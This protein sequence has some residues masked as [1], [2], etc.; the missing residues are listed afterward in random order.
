MS[1][2]LEDVLK[3]M[4]ERREGRTTTDR[5]SAQ[6]LGRQASGRSS[7]A[8]DLNNGVRNAETGA[9]VVGDTS[10]SQDLRAWE[11][12]PKAVR[13]G[14]ADAH[15]EISSVEMLA[16]QQQTFSNSERRLMDTLR[17]SVTVVR[18][19]LMKPDE[20]GHVQTLVANRDWRDIRS[21]RPGNAK[22]RAMAT[23]VRLKRHM[24]RKAKA[25]I[26]PKPEAQ[27]GDDRLDARA[28]VDRS[29]G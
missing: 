7:G 15:Y 14:L 1:T 9:R 18:E 21:G 2:D 25:G 4:Q 19:H 10:A 27:T 6:S 22:G 13:Q 8:T 16:V 29:V 28:R 20:N 24:R 12:L 26:L 17:H 23:N 11:R 3:R 5:A